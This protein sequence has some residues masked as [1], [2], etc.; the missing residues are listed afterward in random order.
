M[1]IINTLSILSA[2]LLLAAMTR[3]TSRGG[4][5]PPT[6]TGGASGTEISACVVSGT[7]IDSCNNPMPNCRVRLR[8]YNYLAGVDTLSPG[9][10]QDDTTDAAG[11]FL[12]DSVP[13]GQYM[14][15]INYAESLGQ[16]IEFGVDSAESLHILLP[17]TVKPMA[18]ISGY[19]VPLAPEGATPVPPSVQ[20][21]GFERSAPIDNMGHFEMKVPPGW[22]RLHLQGVDTS[23]YRG[24]TVL[25]ATPGKHYNIM[26]P[27]NFFFPCDS[28]AC[29]IAYVQ[30]ILDSNNLT[31]LSPE[32]VIVV[33]S[34]HIT[35]LHLRGKALHVLPESVCWILHLRV[36]DVGNNSLQALPMGLANWPKLVT[37]R[38][39][40]NV[41]WWVPASIGML[42]SLREL[43]LSYN[44][45]QS[46]PGPI[47]SIM[48]K[49]LLNLNGNMLCNLGSF[50]E[51]WANYYTPGWREHQYCW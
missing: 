10:I 11:K 31:S 40:S 46:L 50:T 8:P 14:I 7:V 9:E 2:V 16:S 48:P 20:V 21:I 18:T 47:T 39:D 44:L 17:E 34:G 33:M 5:D 36:L 42:M 24:D 22:C 6:F 32:S 1:K 28:L 15:E 3:C 38:A 41:L 25:Y 49:K 26:P 4:D 29:E 51:Q 35:E 30:E 13:P 37:L 45:L 27:P 23:K 43:D 12:L 19:N